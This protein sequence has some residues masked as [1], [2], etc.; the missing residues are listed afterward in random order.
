M[1]YLHEGHLTLIDTARDNGD[2]V[3]LSIYVNPLQFG[4][5]E[6]LDR[7]PRDFERDTDLARGRGVDFVFAPDDNEMY[8]GDTPAVTV[9]APHLSDRLCGL[10]RQGHFEGVLTVVAKLFNIVQPDAAVFGQKDFQQH[11]LIRR[12]VHDLSYPIDIIVAPLIREPDGLAMSS[13][14]IYLS[15]DARASALALSRALRVA[16][17]RY[18]AGERKPAAL[19]QSAR[20]LLD[21]ER[22][23]TLQYVEVVDPASLETPGRADD[24]SVMAVAA[25]VGK[26]RLIDNAILS[27][28]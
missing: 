6:D 20:Q 7:Y 15:A 13:R 25:V 12:M 16:Q 11:V 27:A 28:S 9:H 19:V 8:G 26:T 18:R 4:P 14:N 1:G 24:T 23:V 3:V 5:T 2:V 10:F 21:A 22:G 17:L